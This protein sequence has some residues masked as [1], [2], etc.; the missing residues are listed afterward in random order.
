MG[1]IFNSAIGSLI[2]TLAVIFFVVLSLLSLVIA[3]WYIVEMDEFWIGVITVAGGIAGSFFFSVFVYAFGELVDR[4][5]SI[6]NKI[7]QINSAPSQQ[8]V[9]PSVTNQAKPSGLADALKKAGSTTQ[10][11][12]KRCPH[13]GEYVTS[14]ICGMC[15]N[16]NNLFD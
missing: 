4:A 10:S 16:T 15:G 5:V 11:V 9:V 7:K 13:C 1:S 8:G 2:K 12:R 3:I 6:D 14:G